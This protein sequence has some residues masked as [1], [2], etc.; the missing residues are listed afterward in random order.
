[1]TPKRFSLRAEIECLARPHVFMCRFCRCYPFNT[2]VAIARQ[3]TVYEYVVE[4]NYAV[5]RCC[6]IS[7]L[8]P[9]RETSGD[10]SFQAARDVSSLLIGQQI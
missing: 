3:H 7:L 1:M 5:P 10:G 4:H 9:K 8:N 2:A 6:G